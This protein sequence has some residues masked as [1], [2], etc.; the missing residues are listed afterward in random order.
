M[1]KNVLSPKLKSVTSKVILKEK[2]VL[3]GKEIKKLE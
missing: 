3:Q 1:K 2:R